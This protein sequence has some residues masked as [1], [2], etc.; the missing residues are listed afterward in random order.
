VVHAEGV[1]RTR[2]VPIA[3]LLVAT[4]AVVATVAIVPTGTVATAAP[5]AGAAWAA[6][7]EVRYEARDALSDWSG[8]AEIVDLVVTFDPEDVRTLRLAAVVHP[9]SFSSGNF[10]RDLQARRE[11]F[12]VDA[13]PEARLSARPAAGTPLRPLP[14]GGT[15]SLVLDAELTLHGVTRA[16]RI[17]A[18]LRRGG[19]G[20]GG[21]AAEVDHVHAEA[22]FVV[23]LTAHGMRRPT[24]FGLVTDDEVRV[25]VV[26]SGH[27][28]PEPTPTT[29]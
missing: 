5:D 3:L 20:D 2:H 18:S 13:H 11:V 4:A 9:A 25:S 10:L 7:G 8:V 24:L 6:R 21:A 29:R 26:A 27:P 14:V 22:S 28:G 12:R 17:E 19:S 1:D 23:S 16:Y 15:L